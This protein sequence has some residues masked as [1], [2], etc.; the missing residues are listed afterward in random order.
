[1]RVVRVGGA[2][3]ILFIP[4]CRKKKKKET[5]LSF[6]F[7]PWRIFYKLLPNILMD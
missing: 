5:E 7:N 1:M 6:L 3:L 2:C 4:L